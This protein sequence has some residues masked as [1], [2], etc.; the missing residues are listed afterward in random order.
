M[1]RGLLHRVGRVHGRLSLRFRR[2]LRIS[3]GSLELRF[4]TETAIARRW[5]YPR[6]AG[7]KPHEPPTG[8]LLLDRLGPD[9]VFF[10]LGANL[11][12][13]TVLAANLCSGP[14]GEVHAFEMDPELVPLIRRSLDLNTGAGVVHL[15]C[16]AVTD[17]S[18]EI[19]EFSPTQPENPSTN[20][21][22]AA[23]ASRE[24]G[25][26]A[27][28]LAVSLALD[29]YCERRSVTP[30][31]IKVDIEGA[32]ALALRGMERLLRDRRP[33]LLLEV[34]PVELRSHGESARRVVESLIGRGYGVRPVEDHRSAAGNALLADAT[35]LPEDRPTM[36]LCVPR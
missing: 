17:R 5:F 3:V 29:D 12:Y 15:T 14:R 32:E 16:A 11:G 1:L 28:N 18:G 25:R 10:D 8:E 30:D 4:A 26:S 7:G 36:L 6:Y 33:T 35:S 9:S 27:R 34:H 21:L 23:G 24:T 13:F 31:L 2:R 22:L 19:V 20:R